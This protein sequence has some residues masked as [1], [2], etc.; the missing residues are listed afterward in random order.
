MSF[1]TVFSRAL[2]GVEAIEVVVETHLSNGIPG[3]AIVGL[4][5]TAVRESK[6]RVRSAILTAGL[7][8]PERRITVNLAPAD[9]PKTGGKYDL[10]IALSILAASGQLDGRRLQ[11]FEILGELTLDGTLRKTEAVIPVIL[12][13]RAA[14]RDLILPAANLSELS[15]I[16]YRRGRCAASLLEIIDHLRHDVPLQGCGSA[17]TIRQSSRKNQA[18]DIVI[19]GQVLAKRA[20]QIA[21]SGSHHLLLVGPPGSGKTLLANSLAALLPAL[22]EQQALELAGIKSVANLGLETSSWFDPPL[23]SPHHSTSAIALVGGGSRAKPGEISLAN[24]GVLFLDELTEFR[25]GVLDSLREPLESGQ[26]HVSRANYRV[27]YPARFQLVAAMNPCPCGYASAAHR[28]CR[29]SP[30]QIRRYL[31][32]LSGPLLDRLDLIIEMPGLSSRELLTQEDD[33]TDWTG[34]Q[35]RVMEC[36]CRQLDRNGKLNAQLS[37]AELEHHCRLSKA[38]R[39]KMADAMDKLGLSARAGHGL[40]KVARTI[41]DYEER[42]AIREQDL[43]EALSFRKIRLLESASC[44]I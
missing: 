26:I 4:P 44:R 14:G 9:M 30:D 22:Q 3:F 34:L 36:R 33:A 21:A 7:E 19:R 18:A 15:L 31:G 13:A 20:L 23:R 24:H 32:K 6:E 16:G 40:L 12:A 38:V 35:Q 37:V 27:K 10:A 41:A 39:R 28:E 17:P 5:E 11:G 29:C 43:F 2:L 1:A 42:G 8:F 25:Q